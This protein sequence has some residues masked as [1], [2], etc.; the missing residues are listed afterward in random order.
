MSQCPSKTNLICITF[1]QISF[2]FKLTFVLSLVIGK[3]E[4]TIIIN[5]LPAGIT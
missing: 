2:T 1:L 3:Y 5:A 4:D